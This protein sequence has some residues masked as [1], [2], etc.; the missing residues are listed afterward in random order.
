MTFTTGNTQPAAGASSGS[1][2]TPAATPA[3]SAG[4]NLQR[5]ISGVWKWEQSADSSGQTWTA[6]NPA[7]YT[8]Q[9]NP[10]GTLGMKVDCNTGGGSYQADETNLTIQ[11][12][13]TTLMACPPPTLD[14]EFRQQLGLVGSYFFDGNSLV[15][16]WKMD[17]GS[18]KFA[19]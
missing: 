13:P 8:I 12:G 7:S 15:L 1:A 16:L 2:T 10:D 3:A 4:S 17:S 11:L 18:M 14:N 19:Q 9:F 6:P 5:L